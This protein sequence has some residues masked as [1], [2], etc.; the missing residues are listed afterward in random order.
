MKSFDDLRE[1]EFVVGGVGEPGLPRIANGI[2]VR[3]QFSTISKH[4][5]Y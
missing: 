2:I 1:H 3:V 4:E 5:L